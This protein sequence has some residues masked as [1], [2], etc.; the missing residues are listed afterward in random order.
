M[1]PIDPAA[2]RALCAK[3]VS[4]A[5]KGASGRRSFSRTTCKMSHVLVQIEGVEC[6]AIL[7]VEL[8]VKN[9]PQEAV[10]GDR[11]CRLIGMC[12]ALVWAP[13]DTHLFSAIG[14]SRF[15]FVVRDPSDPDASPSLDRA[16]AAAFEILKTKPAFAVRW[17]AAQI[18]RISRSPDPGSGPARRSSL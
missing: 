8:A 18:A 10:A 15:D 3:T 14:D 5:V 1:N 13:D 9:F 16:L 12:K 2:W 11:S 17:E 7:D 4:R 6:G